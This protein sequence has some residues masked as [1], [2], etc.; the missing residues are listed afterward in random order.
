M[1]QARYSRPAWASMIRASKSCPA[2]VG[3]DYMKRGVL[4][5]VVLFWVGPRVEEPVGEI[6][7]GITCMRVPPSAVSAERVAAPRAPLFPH[8]SAGVVEADRQG[9]GNPASERE[10]KGDLEAE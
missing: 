4:H 1:T 6:S 7:Q 8:S 5:D 10:R 9:G 2:V 3:R